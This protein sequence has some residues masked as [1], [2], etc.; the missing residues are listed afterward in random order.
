MYYIKMGFELIF[1]LIYYKN[2]DLNYC[3]FLKFG[4]IFF[5]DLYF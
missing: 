1:I 2:I 5:D 3:V 4:C